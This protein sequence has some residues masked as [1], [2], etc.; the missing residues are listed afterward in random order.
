MTY[1]EYVNKFLTSH[2][3]LR[4]IEQFIM[5]KRINLSHDEVNIFFNL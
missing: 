4:K 3:R 1:F 2:I 5:Y